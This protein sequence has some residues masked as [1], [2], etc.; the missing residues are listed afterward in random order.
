MDLSPGMNKPG[1]STIQEPAKQITVIDLVPDDDGLATPI[2]NEARGSTSPIPRDLLKVNPAEPILTSTPE[3]PHLV[4]YKPEQSP[5]IVPFSRILSTGGGPLSSYDSVSDVG[6]Y[7]YSIECLLPQKTYQSTP[8]SQLRKL[9]PVSS[10]WARIFM[11][12]QKS[13]PR[14][15]TRRRALKTKEPLVLPRISKSKKYKS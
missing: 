7:H 15:A 10:D 5:E 9:K 14:R 1:S 6:S 12:R 11:K 13:P 8:P 4:T 3:L 2:K